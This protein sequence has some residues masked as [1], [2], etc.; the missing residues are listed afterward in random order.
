MGAM[1]WQN[2]LFALLPAIE[3]TVTAIGHWRLQA[4]GALRADLRHGLL[5]AALALV[6]L[7]P[8]MLAWKAIYGT[9]LAVSPISPQI[10]W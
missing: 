8:Q 4:R 1:R 10:R 3:W 9:W 7:L 2:V 6:G 5:F